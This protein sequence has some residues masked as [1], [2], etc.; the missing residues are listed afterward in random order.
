[1]EEGIQVSLVTWMT[2][3]SKTSQRMKEHGVLL[4]DPVMFSANHE[5]VIAQYIADVV[6]Q[7]NLKILAYNICRDHVHI[8][9]VCIPSELTRIVQKLKSTSARSFNI[10]KDLTTPG[11]REHAPLSSQLAWRGTA[12]NH[13]W[14][15]KFNRRILE[16]TD[17]LANAKF[18]VDNNRYKYGLKEDPRLEKIIRIFVLSKEEAF[19]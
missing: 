17:D 12:Q 10:A 8:I 5:L 2:H 3:N 6:M 14:A 11:T 18:Y 9:I 15:Q 19:S 4:G 7:D 16:T 1:M 13:L